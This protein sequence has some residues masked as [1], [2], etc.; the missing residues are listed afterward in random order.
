ML[1]S[2]LRLGFFWLILLVVFVVVTATDAQIGVAGSDEGD[3]KAPVSS[4]ATIRVIA[5]VDDGR[6]LDSDDAAGGDA[7]EKQGAKVQ[8]GQITIEINGNKHTF[9]L[10]NASKNLDRTFRKVIRDGEKGI[11]VIGGSIEA[12][13]LDPE[14][15]KKMVQ[16]ATESVP[17]SESLAEALSDLPDE[18]RQQVQ[19]LMKEIP[20]GESFRSA[21]AIG[22][23]ELGMEDVELSEFGF[24]GIDSLPKIHFEGMSVNGV[25]ELSK[26]VQQRVEAAMK[27]VKAGTK[28]QGQSKGKA[29]VRVFRMKD[30]KM[31]L[32]HQEETEVSDGS[33]TDASAG[34]KVNLESLNQKMDLLLKQLSRLQSDV[35]AL[36][37]AK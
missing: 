18:V 19:N 10:D 31:E 22:F 11:A 34:D 37:A 30:G 15:V 27:G 26:E 21:I 17:D 28:V 2:N 29:S 24:D 32:M 3:A 23:G 36:K 20:N 4:N 33:K 16:E 5:N 9:S 13:E 35:D 25:E 12:L 14:S 7:A 8:S 1:R 6:K